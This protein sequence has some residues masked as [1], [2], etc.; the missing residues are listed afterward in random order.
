MVQSGDVDFKT[1]DRTGEGTRSSTY[2]LATGNP[3][4][5]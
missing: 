2:G 1:S 3:I 4:G 5:T